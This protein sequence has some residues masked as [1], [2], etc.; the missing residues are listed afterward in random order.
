M[1][2]VFKFFFI[3][4]W[5]GVASVVGWWFLALLTAPP[6]VTGSHGDPSVSGG[7]LG[8]FVGFVLAFFMCI[9]A[10]FLARPKPDP[11]PERMYVD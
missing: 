3:W 10:Y 2:S 8:M 11:V 7:A 1:W 6:V 5:L 4:F 9:P